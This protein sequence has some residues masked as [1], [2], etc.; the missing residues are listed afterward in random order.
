MVAVADV[1]V[2]AMA[3]ARGRSFQTLT[4]VY[5]GAVNGQD[6]TRK[7]QCRSNAPKSISKQRSNN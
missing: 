1:V 3:N 2:A 7:R 6:E 4:R 5:L